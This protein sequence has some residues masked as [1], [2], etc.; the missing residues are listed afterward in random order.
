MSKGSP[1][2][3]DMVFVQGVSKLKHQRANAVKPPYCCPVL[4]I[5]SHKQTV[6]CEIENGPMHG[7]H[8]S[9]VTHVVIDMPHMS[10]NNLAVTF[11][12]TRSSISKS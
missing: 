1:L 10:P 6:A 11:P 3:Q 7:S 9:I 5:Q 8:G 2:A 4:A 12:I